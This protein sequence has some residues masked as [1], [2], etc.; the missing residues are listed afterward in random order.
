M[1]QSR[2]KEET[3]TSEKSVEHDVG[4]LVSLEH[5]F[6]NDF[7]KALCFKLLSEQFQ[8]IRVSLQ[9]KQV[10]HKGIK[11]FKISCKLAVERRR[12]SLIRSVLVLILFYDIRRSA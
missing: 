3:R 2:P 4:P 8:I 6:L 10:G 11:I 7:W 9:P 5:I 1:A 12:G